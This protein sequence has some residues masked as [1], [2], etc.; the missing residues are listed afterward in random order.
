MISARDIAS[1]VTGLLVIAAIT[2]GTP[3]SGHRDQAH[4]VTSEEA[5]R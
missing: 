2:V 3:P 4:A 5:A 1:F